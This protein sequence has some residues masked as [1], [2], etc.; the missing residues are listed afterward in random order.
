LVFKVLE[1]K[2]RI[3]ATFVGSN[4]LPERKT[5][6]CGKN[7]KASLTGGLFEVAI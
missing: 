4:K 5:N 2:N 6:A 3:P 1:P 7:K